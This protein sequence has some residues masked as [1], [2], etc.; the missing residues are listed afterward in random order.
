MY[1]WVRLAIFAIVSVLGSGGI[2]AYLQ[3]R[4]T[5]N[6]ATSRLLMG[7]AYNYITNQ[8]INYIDR[9]WISK[10]ELEELNKYYF[11]PYTDLGGNGVAERVMS[12]VKK[13]PL[14][15][16]S[17]YAEILNRHQDEGFINN[18]RFVRRT[19]QEASVE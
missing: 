6:N 7:M 19:N 17:P 3:S 1:A 8:G 9:G 12:E 4:G 5:R 13:L 2:V 10:D 15:P 14:R 11:R 16:Q 18:V